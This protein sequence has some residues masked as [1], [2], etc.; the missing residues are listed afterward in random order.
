MVNYVDKKFKKLDLAYYEPYHYYFSIDPFSLHRELGWGLEYYSYVSFIIDYISELNF[1]KVIDVGCGDGFLLNNLAPKFK[2]ASF[3]GIDFS[4]KAIQHAKAFKRSDNANFIV[5]DIKNVDGEF[6]IVLLIE[7]LEHIADENIEYFISA[8]KEKVKDNGILIV[9]VPTTNIP[10]IDTHH[11]HYDLNLLIKHIGDDCELINKFYV[12]DRN[13]I[14]INL[15][16]RFLINRLFI[17]RNKN[18]VQY[19]L[20]IAKK[21][22]YYRNANKGAHLISIF[23]K[24]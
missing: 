2:N 6:D 22:I 21:Y 18:I 24:K 23:E 12:Y 15:I 16:N 8:L 9:S 11:R 20:K 3:L 7:V 17:L 13:H 1:Q 19:L 10:L 4:D 5:D 14:I